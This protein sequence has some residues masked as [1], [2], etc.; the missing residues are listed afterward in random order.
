MGP[1]KKYACNARVIVLKSL[2]TRVYCM[3]LRSLRGI[4]AF[5]S[6]LWFKLKPRETYYGQ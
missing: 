4:T 5:I 6:N 1:N 3:H 2:I